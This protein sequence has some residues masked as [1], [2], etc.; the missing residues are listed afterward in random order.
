MIVISPYR[1][2]ALSLSLLLSCGLVHKAL[3]KDASASSA[4]AAEVT[5]ALE[6]TKEQNIA[7]N[8]VPVT[9]ANQSLPIAQLD[10]SFGKYNGARIRSLLAKV[11]TTPANANAISL[12]RGLACYCLGR[13]EEAA[14][15]F[16]RCSDFK[17]A[18]PKHLYA[19]GFVYS[20]VDEYQKAIKFFTLVLKKL[21]DSESY[22]CRGDCYA[23]LK[24]YDQAISDYLL[25]AKLSPSRRGQYLGS[26]A[27]VLRS[28][29]KYP[30]AIANF[31][32][33]IKN[34][35]IAFL[36]SNLR[37][38]A[39]CYQDLNRWSEAVRDYSET[40]KIL[41]TVYKGEKKSIFLSES[42]FQR[43]KC[44]DKLGKPAL[45]AAD[46]RRH[47]QIGATLAGDVL[48]D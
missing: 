8:S 47:A 16:D 34:S 42:Y 26:A 44:Y 45:A 40:I 22:F 27:F 29:R 2:L 20:R 37:A 41:Q 13:H 7:Y 31:T 38:R 39:L 17:D 33:A 12:W 11:K 28:Q 46:R 4:G 3:A 35:P 5:S 23:S 1:Y 48:S 21:P 10:A 19:V 25:A 32:E 15:D 30:E 43:A 36:P 9:T 14:E 6:R 18:S 24:M